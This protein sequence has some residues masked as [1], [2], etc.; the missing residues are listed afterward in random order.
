MLQLQNR[1][2]LLF[3]RQTL[4]QH[5]YHFFA[6]FD[7]LFVPRS[8]FPADYPSCSQA[9]PERRE[10]GAL[11]CG[12]RRSARSHGHRARPLC[13]GAATP[14]LA[15]TDHGLSE[16]GNGPAA[17]PLGSAAPEGAPA[18]RGRARWRRPPRPAPALCPR[19]GPARRRPPT[20]TPSGASAPPP[21]APARPS[22]P[23][24]TAP[25][26]APPASHRAPGRA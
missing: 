3:L 9:S 5:S 8:N 1:L 24:V 6:R 18:G 16:G 2:H 22:A 26:P 20:A 21:P 10:R 13:E 14:G 12:T 19:C 25:P 15:A 23:D 11:L 7:F 4:V 17:A